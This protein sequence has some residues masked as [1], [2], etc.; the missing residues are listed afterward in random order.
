MS[1]PEPTAEEAL[2]G[3]GFALAATLRIG[4]L[5]LIALAA[6]FI[7][8]PLVILAVVVVVPLIVLG[9]VFALVALPVVAV[10]RVHRHRSAHPHHLVRRLVARAERKQFA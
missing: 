3:V 5:A 6:V 9:A 4:E 8:P 10:R 7:A 2:T 1:H